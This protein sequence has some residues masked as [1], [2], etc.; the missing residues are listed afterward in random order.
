MWEFCKTRGLLM[1]TCYLTREN[2]L[3]NQMC[4][5]TTN[6]SNT[7]AWYI[8]II[9]PAI[10]CQLAAPLMSLRTG[11]VWWKWPP[12]FTFLMCLIQSELVSQAY[13]GTCNRLRMC[14]EHLG[15]GWHSARWQLDGRSTL[16]LR[17]KMARSGGHPD[18]TLP[19]I[20]QVLAS[21]QPE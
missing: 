1:W 3:P 16:L 11:L 17:T 9:P 4:L 8:L 2:K 20:L 21:R 15:S 12:D 14:P 10:F 7:S 6:F 18:P 5:A 19:G 13:E